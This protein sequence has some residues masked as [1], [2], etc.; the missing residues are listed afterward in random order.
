MKARRLVPRLCILVTVL[1]AALGAGTAAAKTKA[2]PKP[3]P[4][5]ALSLSVL[6]SRP[7]LVTGGTS[8]V[9]VDVPSG[10]PIAKVHVRRNG[11]DVTSVFSAK[12]DNPRR[13]IGLVGN[14]RAGDNRIS[15]KVSSPRAANPAQLT[16]YNTSI[17][18]PLFSGA[19]QSPFFCSTAAAG[20][21]AAATDG[22]CAASPAVTYQ[23]MST[24]GNFKP[25]PD[26]AVRPADLA[27][28]TTR[29]G[30]TVDYVVRVE[31]GVIDRSIY[32]W[33]IL[34]PGGQMAE[35]WNHRLYYTF[36]GGCTTGYQQ[37]EMPLD[38][39]LLPRPLSEGYSVVSSSLNRF[40]T[41]CNDVLSA[42]ATT[43][44]KEHVIKSLGEAPVWT[45]GQGPSG[46]SV[47]IQM[48]AQN[49]PGL[50][51]GILPGMSFPDNSLENSPDC[52]LLQNYFGT[53]SG[54]SLTNAQRVAISGLEDPNG[55]TALS[56]QAD[57]INAS[58]G[59]DPT[60]VPPA[61]VFNKTTNPTGLRCSIFDTLI[62]VYGRN[63]TT[64]L[65]R[66][67]DD[68]IGVQY[69]LAALQASTITM[70]QFLDLNQAIGGFDQNGDI[71]P[72]RAAA[73]PDALKIAYA[74]GRVNQGA[75]GYPDV[76][77]IDARQY[78]DTGL[79]VHQYIYSYEM[80]AR[81]RRTNGTAG[82]QVMWRASGGMNVNPMQVAAL[83]TMGTWLDTIHSDKSNQTLAQKVISDKP[84]SAVDACWI[85]GSRL[86]D[87]AEIGDTGP[88]STT[89]PPHSLPRLK[90]GQPLGDPVMKCSLTPVNPASYGSLTPTQT[91]QLQADFPDGVCDYS[92]AG[93]AEQLASGAWQEFGPSRSIPQRRRSLRLTS[94]VHRQGRSTAADLTAKLGPCPSSA[95]QRVI[96]QRR[97]KG[98]WVSSGSRIAGGGSCEAHV[99]LHLSGKVKVRAISKSSTGYAGA[100]SKVKR[101]KPLPQRSRS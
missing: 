56:Q 81:L 77:V 85:G 90:A 45:I 78:T 71:V 63:P 54:S 22:T 100:H 20:L 44:I 25:L 62:N 74:T 95:W 94:K 55:C 5:P 8:L 72:Q 41:S 30:Q 97:G 70:N 83:D 42:E 35:G 46:G 88:C 80:R 82:N 4:F 28:T 61:L 13:L 24:D 17:D 59:C 12:P 1:I 98:K 10:N 99:T 2:K 36:G 26:P 68:D 86:D 73:D 27:Q 34:A 33:S 52:R 101:L 58:E 43:M 18:G 87:P 6:S 38:A 47:Q 14:L 89:Y 16:V 76:P 60:A 40:A 21:G 31:T 57:V 96:F 91:A 32:R 37:G 93:P 3:K 15:A 64:G 53:P 29:D 48:M 69:G 66:R 84:T 67:T 7:D 19:R 49:Y 51:D 79:N 65:A 11:V 75:G 92:K 9:A 39:V 23:Y 50:L